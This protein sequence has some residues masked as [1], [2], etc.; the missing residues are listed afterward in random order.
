MSNT[1]HRWAHLDTIRS[2]IMFLCMQHSILGS[3]LNPSHILCVFSVEYRQIIMMPI[4]TV[5]HHDSDHKMILSL[6]NNEKVSETD[7]QRKSNLQ[8][9]TKTC[10]IVILYSYGWNK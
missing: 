2:I 6:Q 4:T 3:S 1:Q 8:K 9:Q 5:Q 7:K 10:P